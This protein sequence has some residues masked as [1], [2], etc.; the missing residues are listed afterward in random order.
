MFIICLSTAEVEFKKPKLM[1]LSGIGY[2]I[3]VAAFKLDDDGED[4]LHDCKE[5]DSKMFQPA[6]PIPSSISLVSLAGNVS[7]SDSTS[8]VSDGRVRQGSSVGLILDSPSPTVRK[9]VSIDADEPGAAEIVSKVSPEEV[10]QHSPF[11]TFQE[12]IEL[13]DPE[14]PTHT[15]P[16]VAP[17]GGESYHPPTWEPATDFNFPV[18]LIPLKIESIDNLTFD[19]FSEITHI[20]DGSNANV[21]LAKFNDEKVRFIT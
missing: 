1:F 17:N 20:A 2:A 15:A 13:K 14:L 10:V 16:A 21:Y 8:T 5:L 4:A 11:V 3:Y 18:G 9:R 19:S 12:Q 6:R 7:L